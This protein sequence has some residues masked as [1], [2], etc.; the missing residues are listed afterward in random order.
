MAK[1]KSSS[2]PRLATITECPRWQRLTRATAR[3]LRDS[4]PNPAIGG[5]KGAKTGRVTSTSNEA[6]SQPNDDELWSIRT[7]TG[8]L[9]PTGHDT[10][11]PCGALSGALKLLP[12]GQLPLWF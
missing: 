4:G 1:P 9:T 7:V 6:R 10:L 3:L 5:S 8:R 2:I 12:S 11:E